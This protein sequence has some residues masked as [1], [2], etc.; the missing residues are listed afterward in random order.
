MQRTDFD[1]LLDVLISMRLAREAIGE[2]AAKHSD[3]AYET[4][5]TLVALRGPL[6]ERG[7]GRP[8]DGNLCCLCR[9]GCRRV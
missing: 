8:M 6:S 3:A 1:V 9:G 7:E 4:L 5:R 2:E